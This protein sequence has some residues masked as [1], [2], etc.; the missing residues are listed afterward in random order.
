MNATQSL[1]SQ[2]S[3]MKEKMANDVSMADINNRRIHMQLL[4]KKIYLNRVVQAV[5]TN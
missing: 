1:P 4:K 5:P 2:N 3:W